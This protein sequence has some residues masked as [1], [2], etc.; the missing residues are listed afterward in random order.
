[1]ETTQAINQSNKIENITL[2][3]LF[4]IG[5][6]PPGITLIPGGSSLT[7]PIQ[8][9]RSQ[10]FTIS[11]MIELNCDISL[12]TTIHWIIK[13]C[14]STICSFEIIVSEK[15]ITTFSELYVPSRILPYGIY[16]LTLS[17]VM[18]DVP[19]L[20]S[21]STAYVRI[22]ATGV[23]ANLVQLGTSMI[24]RGDQQDLLLD[25][26]SFSVDPDE[27]SFDPSVSIYRLK[28]LV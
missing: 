7:S 3:I 9:R 27:D 11:S 20:K 15:V 4:I 10:D 25:P 22:T 21:S 17:M 16:E 18:T 5:C 19:T 24:T 13:N 2:L 23:T 26:G 14:T 28:N 1:M 8:Y 6:Y 12:A